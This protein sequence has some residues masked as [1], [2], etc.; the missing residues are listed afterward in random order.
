MG[1]VPLELQLMAGMYQLHLTSIEMVLAVVL[2][3]R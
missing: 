2:A 1:L 3:T